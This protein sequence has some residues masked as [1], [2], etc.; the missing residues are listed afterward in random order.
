[1]TIR[2]ILRFKG[3]RVV[4]A[5]TGLTVWEAVRRMVDNRVGAL[6][7]VDVQDRPVGIFTERDLLR[8]VSQNPDVL[9]VKTLDEVMTRDLV[10]GLPDDDVDGV[11][12]LMTQ[13]RLRHLPVLESGSLVGLVSIGD[14]VKAKLNDTS[15]EVHHLQEYIRGVY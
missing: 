5:E 11:L 2:D 4:T 15:F 10:V 14:I 9:K 12:N 8:L 3:G 1:M 13:R 6:L 7:V